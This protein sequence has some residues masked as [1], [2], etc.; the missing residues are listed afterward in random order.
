MLGGLAHSWQYRAGAVRMY[1]ADTTGAG[2]PTP[3]F[4]LAVKGLNVGHLMKE[5]NTILYMYVLN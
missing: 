3:L 4:P 1:G 5:F 2:A